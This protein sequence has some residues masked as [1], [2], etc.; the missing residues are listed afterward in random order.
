MFNI[1]S[2]ISKPISWRNSENLIHQN[3]GIKTW[4]D[5]RH[6]L[7]RVDG[8]AS[9]NQYGDKF[10]YLHGERHRTDGPAVELV[11]G[12][13]AWYQC[14]KLHR[15][16]GPAVMFNGTKLNG[17]GFWYRIWYLHGL[18][19]CASGPAYENK[20][21]QY[22]YWFHGVQVSKEEFYSPEFQVRMV[23]EQ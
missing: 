13:K 20:Y 5:D 9:I 16:D 18:K 19:H 7:H 17:Y 3:E 23:M 11:N 4:L 6:R 8:P 12:Y 14:D 21:G 22:Q 15:M 1:M 2:A 10:W